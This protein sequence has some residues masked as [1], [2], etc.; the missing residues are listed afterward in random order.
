[1]NANKFCIEGK[2]FFLTYPH[3]DATRE[4]CLEAVTG[5]LQGN[6]VTNHVVAIEAHEDGTPH[7]HIM[8]V[9][10]RK[11]KICNAKF[12]DFD[13]FHG[14]YQTVKN[15]LKVFD[16]ITKSDSSALNNFGPEG[17]KAVTKNMRQVVAKRVLEGEEV[18]DLVEEYPQ[19]LFGFKRLQ[20]DIRAYEEAKVEY[21]P[22]PHFLRN[23]WG[24]VVMP[25]STKKQRHWWIYSQSPN[26]GKTTWARDLAAK[27][28]AYIKS[29][30]FSYWNCTGR[31][32]ILI[33][34][35]YNFAGLRYHTLNQLCD[36]LYEARIFMG[37]VRRV[38]SNMVIVLANVS[39][40]ELYPFKYATL[41]AR[42]IE[43][44]IE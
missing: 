17:L 40:R 12:F 11:K 10:E 9:L 34:D 42:F 26:R 21:I 37:G 31:E 20:D 28:G 15:R 3:C 29:S 36:G 27:Y 41:E 4:R 7:I 22:P 30:D 44:C 19:L 43:K 8:V 5:C 35:D 38:A 1:M 13:G 39:I 14:N 16:Y 2:A 25:H 33:L 6:V 24:L 32:P 18:K 23:D